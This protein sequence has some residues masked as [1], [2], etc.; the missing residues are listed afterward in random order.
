MNEIH[1]EKDH[2]KINIL[3][4][5]E[6][7]KATSYRKLLNGIINGGSDPV[8]RFLPSVSAWNSNGRR[9]S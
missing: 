8:Y 9:P 2:R 7:L 1:I 3:E 6:M 4:E 5:T